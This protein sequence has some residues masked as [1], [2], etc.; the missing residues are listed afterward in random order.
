MA[1]NPLIFDVTHIEGNSQFLHCCINFIDKKWSFLTT[2]VYAYNNEEGRR[3]LWAE[4]NEKGADRP[5][6]LVGDFND[7]LKANERIGV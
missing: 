5:W 2:I 7:I 3:C 4:L 6:L 1:W